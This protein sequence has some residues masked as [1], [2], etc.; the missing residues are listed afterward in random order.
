MDHKI[1][2]RKTEAGNTAVL[3]IVE[4]FSD[5][6]HLMCVKD[7]T[8]ETTARAIVHNVIP[9]WGLSFQLYSDKGPSFTSALF[10]HINSLL[11]IRHVPMS[12]RS[13]GQAESVV[14][15]LVEHLKIYAKD[16]L[17]IEEAIPLIE[18]CLRATTNSKLLLSPHEIV[19]G[20]PMR[21]GI[22]GHPKPA[23]S[24]AAPDKLAYYRWLS[25]ELQRLHKAVKIT[26]EEMKLDDKH[27][28]DKAHRVVTPS[29]KV[30]DRVLLR[31]NRVKPGALKVVTRQRFFGPYVI[32]QVVQGRP[33]VGVAYQLVDEK[34]GRIIRNLVTSDRLKAF[35]VNRDNFNKRLPRFNTGIDAQTSDS[36][37]H[38]NKCDK[39]NS[40]QQTSEPSPLEIMRHR[41]VKGKKQYLVR[42][43]DNNDYWCDWVNRTLLNHYR[44]KGLK[45][46]DI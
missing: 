16:D 28:Y 3:V 46:L 45:H 2:T 31:D 24:D 32:K 29:W 21:L 22:P 42:Y 15:R 19:F 36:V 34:T 7:T 11:G 35:N 14:K 41:I 6:P 33:N 40:S 10:S 23:T 4:C 9:M 20:R 26:R 44:K 27:M 39:E 1:L 13:N 17:S 30:N 8:A 37:K 43:S 18:I 38:Q 5:Y 25:T 12:S